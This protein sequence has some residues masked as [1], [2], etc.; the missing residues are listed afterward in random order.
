MLPKAEKNYELI[1]REYKE[2]HMNINDV[3][4]A[5]KEK[6]EIEEE[7]YRQIYLSNIAYFRILEILDALY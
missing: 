1:L 2:D 6:K 3:L 5:L 7:K 4:L